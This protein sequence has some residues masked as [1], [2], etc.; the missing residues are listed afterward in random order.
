MSLTA[1][2][3]ADLAGAEPFPLQGCEKFVLKFPGQSLGEASPKYPKDFEKISP[4][5]AAFPI[6]FELSSSSSA[7]AEVSPPSV[8]QFHR[9]FF[10][11]GHITSNSS[12]DKGRS[13]LNKHHF[14]L[15][16]D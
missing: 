14:M 8:D 10:A 9:C 15:S 16:L 12:S 13:T 2:R 6:P 5:F 3:F 11:M 7:I 1:L 4:S